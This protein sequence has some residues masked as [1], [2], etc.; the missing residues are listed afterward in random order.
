MVEFPST[1][2]RLLFAQFI[3]YL[4]MLI[5]GFFDARH[6]HESSSSYRVTFPLAILM[7]WLIVG[8]YKFTIVFIKQ[9]NGVK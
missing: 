4:I 5:H 8:L 1:S 9:L 7:R 2:P 6:V 3:S